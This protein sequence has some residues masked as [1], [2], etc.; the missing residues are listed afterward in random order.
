MYELFTKKYDSGRS[1]I[2]YDSRESLY[3][4]GAVAASHSYNGAWSASGDLYLGGSGSTFGKQFTGSMMEFRLW[5][6]PLKETRFENHVA[7]PKA[8]DGN[9]PSASFTDLPLRFSFDDNKNLSTDK[10]I[11]N[12]APDQVTFGKTGRGPGQLRDSGISICFFVEDFKFES[13][14]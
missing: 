14:N 6:T 3:I 2:Q 10:S 12:V 7:A 9:H 11:P 8:V 1:D 5:T 13:I 4:D